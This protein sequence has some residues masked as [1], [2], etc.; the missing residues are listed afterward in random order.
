MLVKSFFP[1]FNHDHKNFIINTLISITELHYNL[2]I[3]LFCT[4]L[5][6]TMQLL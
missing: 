3:Q 2:L 1:P 4:V 5:Y 6:K